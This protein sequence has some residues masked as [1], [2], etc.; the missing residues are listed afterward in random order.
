MLRQGEARFRSKETIPQLPKFSSNYEKSFYFNHFPA[1]CLKMETIQQKSPPIAK[2]KK[3]N[4][5]ANKLH[6]NDRK[7]TQISKF[8]ENPQKVASNYQTD[9]TK[10]SSF[11]RNPKQNPKPQKENDDALG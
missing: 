9:H 3:L 5:K 2:K 1:Q 10:Y 4:P 8:N 6:C 11:D 7:K